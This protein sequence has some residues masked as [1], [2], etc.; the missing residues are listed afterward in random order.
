MPTM[1]ISAI[2]GAKLPFLVRGGASLNC[3][4]LIFGP[5]GSLQIDSADVPL[6]PNPQ[7]V[8]SNA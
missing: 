3:T 6:L 5:D 2:F 7:A 8:R 4:V 1:P